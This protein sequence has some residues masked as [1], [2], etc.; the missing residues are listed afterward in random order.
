MPAS[1]PAL[2]G[3]HRALGLLLAINLFNYIDRYVLAAVEPEI[4]KAFFAAD[5]P[6]AMA[7]TGSLATAF[8][9]SYMIMAP[10]FGWLADRFSRWKLIGACVILWSL[11]TA[12]SGF[13]A[14]F[15]LLLTTRL[16]VGVGEAGYGPSA[17]TV[18][19]D[20]FPAAVRGRILSYFYMAIPV[21]S[22]LG[23][24]IGGQLA[25]A[26]GWRWAFY[27]VA[28]PGIV[29][30]LLCFLMREPARG[31]ADGA[32]PP[33]H[34]TTLS[35][36]LALFRN[37]SYVLNTAA[38]TAMTFAIGGLSFWVPAYIFDF[39]KAGSLEQVN[40]VFGGITVVAGLLATL[41]GGMLG[42]RLQKRYGGA[43]FLVSGAGMFLSF[44]F[45]V[46]M[47]YTPFPAAWALLF[48]AIFFLFFNTGPANAAIVNVTPAP[49]RATAFALNI[50]LIH[51]LGDAISPPLI[52]AIAGRSNLNTAFLMVASVMLVA[53]LFWL[54]GMRFLAADTERALVAEGAAER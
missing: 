8:L 34:K 42:D 9:L 19:A 39:R 50:F 14:T 22:A 20:L 6:A 4:R 27:A 33:K 1:T 45:V 11:A 49:I 37:R 15:A 52:G 32:P 13:A 16:L 3:A 53:S 51:A 28:V 35:D 31:A 5:D 17:P 2:P 43:Y 44:P 40:L 41:S 26:Y 38:M 7:K 30:G 10:L 12:G 29:L 47:L 21:G 36:Y 23:F 25:A 46:A 18:I 54:L 48:F 24:V